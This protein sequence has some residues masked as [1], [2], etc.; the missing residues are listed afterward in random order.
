MANKSCWNWPRN[1]L[2][3]FVRQILPR[4]IARRRRASDANAASSL[5]IQNVRLGARQSCA[6]T[7]KTTRNHRDLRVLHHRTRFSKTVQNRIN[8]YHNN[9]R[10]CVAKRV[11]TKPKNPRAWRYFSA[12]Y[13]NRGAKLPVEKLPVTGPATSNLPIGIPMYGLGRRH[14]GGKRITI[15]IGADNRT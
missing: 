9:L 5:T 13:R 1:L 8:M 6:H 15:K 2:R 14:A 7:R 3:S 11:C 4:K 10:R 12:P